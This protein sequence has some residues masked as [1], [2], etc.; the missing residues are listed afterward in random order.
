MGFMFSPFIDVTR[1][2]PKKDLCLSEKMAW[3]RM[4]SEVSVI[5]PLVRT[6]G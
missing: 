6:F 1:I 5:E 4:Q 3:D 2:F